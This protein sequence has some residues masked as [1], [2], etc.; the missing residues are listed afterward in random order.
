MAGIG[1]ELRKIYGRK[2]LASNIWGTI[3]A[4]MTTIAPAILSAVLLLILKLIMDFAGLTVYEGRFFAGLTTWVFIISMLLSVMFAAPVSRYIA[5]CIFLDKEYDICPSA[6]GVLAISSIVSGIVMLI[7]C[8]ALYFDQPNTSPVLLVSYYLLGVLLTNAYSLMTFASALK[9]YKA[10]TFGFFIGFFLAIG[11]YFVLVLLVGL[12]KVTSACVGLTCC[13]FVVDFV[14]IFQCIRAFG[15]PIDKYF[16]FL[17]YLRKY[18]ILAI[19]GFTY[20][21]GIYTPTLMYWAFSDMAER[22]SIFITSPSFDIA[23]F[24]AVVVNVPS[25]VIFVVKVETAFY[26]RYTRYVSALNNGTHEMI[27][28]ERKSMTSVLWQQLFFVYEIQFIITIVEIC[29]ASAFFPYLNAST[30]MLQ[31]FVVLC[32]AIYAVFCMYF[33]IVVFYYFSDY[34]GACKSSVVFLVVTFIGAVVAI[35]IQGFYP[36]PLLVGGICGWIV[37]FVLLRRRMDRLDSFLMCSNV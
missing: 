2:T 6:F 8:I 10:L 16:K 15:N 28:K 12:D 22:V 29:L 32:L 4:T 18:K 30:N 20:T 21:L 34:A 23:L 1:F 3:Y 13:Y 36:V 11:I 9:H 25:L 7:L 5:D 31:M 14:L 17:E 26:D 33:T 19:S 27:E 35:L 24:L 37:A